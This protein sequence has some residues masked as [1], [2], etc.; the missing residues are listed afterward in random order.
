[1]AEEFF[2]ACPNVRLL[3]VV[4]NS[5]VWASSF[6]GQVEKLEVVS[7]N[8]IVSISKHCPSLLELNLSHK[9]IYVNDPALDKTS[10]DWSKVGCKLERLVLSGFSFSQDGLKTIRK[11]CSNLKHIDMRSFREDNRSIAVFLG[12]VFTKWTRMNWL[13]WPVIV[14]MQDFT[15]LL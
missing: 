15:P 14:K 1:M 5:G 3:S 9:R 8:P 10:I 4:D 12:S 11:H 13:M 2:R 7:S 6:A